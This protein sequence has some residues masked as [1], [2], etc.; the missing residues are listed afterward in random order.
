MNVRDLLE[1]AIAETGAELSVTA[2]EARVLMAQEASRLLLA[3]GEPGF[4]R[5]LRASRDRVALELGID[6]SESAAAA[7]QRLVG[8]I[9]GILFKLA[10]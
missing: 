3:S 7:D 9:Q 6:A 2:D 5:V 4:G 1:D 8:V 10:T